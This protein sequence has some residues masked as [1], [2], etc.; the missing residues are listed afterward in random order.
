M[1]YYKLN[2]FGTEWEEIRN[3]LEINYKLGDYHYINLFN[4]DLSWKGVGYYTKLNN[5]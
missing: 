4:D 3:G 5:S 2:A 1:K